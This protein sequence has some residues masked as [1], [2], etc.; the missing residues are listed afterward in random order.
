MDIGMN[1]EFKVKLTPKD[2]KAVYSQSLPL[3]I[4]LKE[5]LIVELALMHKY[6]IIT[7]LPFSKYASPIFAQRKPNGKLRL[8]VDLR[9]INTLIADD[10]T[11]NNHPLSNLSDAAQHLAGKSLFCKLD[12][13]QAYHCLQMADQRSVEMLA[14]NFASWTLPTKDLHKVSAD[15][16]LLFRVSCANTWTQLSK[17]TNVLNTWMTLELQPIMLRISPGTFGHSSGAFAMQ[18]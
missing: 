13:S 11:N 17:L 8:L 9:K 12:C 16:W 3:P 15:L 14:F 4:H 18:D 1:T 6:G 2:D 7:V 5:D 10:Y